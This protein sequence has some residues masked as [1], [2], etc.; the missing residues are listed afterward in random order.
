[1]FWRNPR[2]L[3]KENVNLYQFVIKRHMMKKNGEM[4]V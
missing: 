2:S 1:M 3:S 4:E